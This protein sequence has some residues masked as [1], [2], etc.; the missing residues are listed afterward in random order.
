[1]PSIE[2]PTLGYDDIMPTILKIDGYSIRVYTHDH[3]P[4]HVHVVGVDGAVVFHLN[5]PGGPIEVR[6]S[7][8]SLPDLKIRK[9]ARAVSLQIQRLCDE[10]R[11]LHACY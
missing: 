2:N 8:Q 4:A 1:M 3:R 5:C 6:E 11:K 9:L 10:W 7:S